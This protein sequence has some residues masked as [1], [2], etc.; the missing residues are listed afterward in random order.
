MKFKVGKVP[1]PLAVMLVE[2]TLV[3][4]PFVTVSSVPVAFTKERL[5]EE[6]VVRAILV[7]VA[8]VNVNPW[9]EE[10]PEIF[11]VDP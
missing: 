6:A 5:V 9:N 3:I 7:P 4:R 11:R 1:E 8:F 2:E 10:T